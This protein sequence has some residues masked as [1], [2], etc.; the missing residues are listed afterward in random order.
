MKCEKCSAE[1]IG[2]AIICRACDHNNAMHRLSQWR[3][4]RTGDMRKQS[5]IRITPNTSTQR[6][7][8]VTEVDANLI[9]FPASSEATPKK[10]EATPSAGEMESELSGFP[11]WREQL[12]EKVRQARERRVVQNSVVRDEPDDTHLDPNPIVAAALKRIR[13][14]S[15]PSTNPT[16]IR[17]ARRGAQA[18]ALLEEVEPE[19]EPQAKPPVQLHR[20]VIKRQDQPFT[21]ISEPASKP[22]LTTKP[23][24][25]R[26]ETQDQPFTQISERTSKPSITTKPVSARTETK[27]ESKNLTPGLV[28]ENKVKPE[29]KNPTIGVGKVITPIPKGRSET[30]EPKK[31]DHQQTRP[32]PPPIIAA[33]QKRLETQIIEIPYFLVSEIPNLFVNS[34]TLWVRIL[35]GA[36]D[37]EIIFMAFLPIFAAYATLNTSPG[38][39]AFLILTMLLAAIIFVYQTISLMIADR[40][41]GMA[42][43]KLRLIKTVDESHPISRRRKLLRAWGATIAFLCPP[44]NFAVIRLNR[45]RLSLPDLIS[46]TSPVEE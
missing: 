14:T 44:L 45:N 39:E 18:A 21:Q 38:N 7:H 27:V 42:I 43:L 41:F 28:T 8:S 13:R 2:A 19:L 17:T 10:S 40:T 20:P 16:V 25:A 35:A 26:T 4:K 24:S 46:G 37:F 31:L 33:P 3:A 22:S 11:P 32:E 5:A 6:T 12:K 1:L 30:P 9:R 36:C 15:Q 29:T 34:A 23:V